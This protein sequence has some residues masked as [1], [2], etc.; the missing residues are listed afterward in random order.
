MG[1][2]AANS[3]W[4]PDGDTLRVRSISVGANQT[5]TVGF[6]SSAHTG[7]GRRATS[8]ITIAS[9]VGPAGR[10]A[11]LTTV[12]VQ[13]YSNVYGVWLTV[14]SF[15]GSDEYFPRELIIGSPEYFVVENGG[16]IRCRLVATT[17]GRGVAGLELDQV[18]LKT[19]PVP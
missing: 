6:Q 15:T 8:A 4:N 19:V 3:V 17:F 14:G 16:P 9:R 5:E 18:E 10:K 7:A 12:T 2:P 13:V 11:E 1:S